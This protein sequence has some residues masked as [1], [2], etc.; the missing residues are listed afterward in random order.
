MGLE[1]GCTVGGEATVSGDVPQAAGDTG[2]EYS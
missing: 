2:F 1:R